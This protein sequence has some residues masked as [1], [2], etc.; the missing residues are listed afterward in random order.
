MSTAGAKRVRCRMPPCMVVIVVVR[1]TC[2][3][4][5]H[6]WR[7]IRPKSINWGRWVVREGG[8]LTRG[9]FKKSMWKL[10]SRCHQPPKMIGRFGC[11]SGLIVTGQ[12]EEGHAA[13]PDLLDLAITSATQTQQNPVCQD[14]GV[15][16]GGL[17][18]A[19]T[20]LNFSTMLAILAILAI[21]DLFGLSQKHAGTQGMIDPLSLA[22][23]ILFHP[24][25]DPAL[26]GQS[27]TGSPNGQNL[28]GQSE[29][30]K[31]RLTSG[32]DIN[33]GPSCWP[34]ITRTKDRSSF[35]GLVR[36]RAV[37]LLTALTPVVGSICRMCGDSLAS[38]SILPSNSLNHA[39]DSMD[40][41]R[42]NLV[43]SLDG[44]LYCHKRQGG[45]SNAPLARSIR[46]GHVPVCSIPLRHISLPTV[47]PVALK[48]ASVKPPMA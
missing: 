23:C 18:S 46:H 41:C 29:V 45:P 37:V 42:E 40:P 47:F 22:A 38:S 36:L 21:L 2:Q 13:L 17:R 4:P 10:T 48:L 30:W 24:E 35:K 32:L 43:P 31:M 28:A 44:Y 34:L 39:H 14:R 27:P 15:R 26:S 6:V 25:R 19:L 33:P 20:I 5:D 8:R 1:R 3:P 7:K 16:E 11:G 12:G 9:C